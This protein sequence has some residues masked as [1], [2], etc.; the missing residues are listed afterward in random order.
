VTRFVAVWAGQ[1]V[2]LVGSGLS[3]FAIAVWVYGETGDVADLA[4]LACAGYLPLVVV[5]PYGG[6]LADRFDRRIV[7]LACD[8]ASAVAIALAL[9]CA[10]AG[11]LS[12]GVATLLVAVASSAGAIQWPAYEAALVAMVPADRLGRANGLVELSRGAA[13]LLAPVIGGVAYA[14]IGLGGILAIDVASF[15]I[16]ILPLVAIRFPAHPRP[17]REAADLRAAWQVVAKR[18]GL[19]AMLALFAVTNFTFAVTELAFRP[20]VLDAGDPW[21][22]G[23]VLSTVGCGM[24]AGAAAMAVWSARTASRVTAILAFQLVEGGALI[25]AGASTTLA[26]RCA[27][28]FAYGVVI[29]LTFGCARVIWQ[30]HIPHELQGRVAALRNAIVIA[31]IPIGYA[32]A[33]PIAYVLGPHLAIVAMGAVTWAAAVATFLFAPYRNVERSLAWSEA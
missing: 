33:A 6:V 15:A 16:G 31:A 29:P 10:G 17:P 9:G 8:L 1:L 2:S 24:V 13:Q 28:A 11:R 30:L 20:L 21:Q 4:R 18:R 14:A 23:V 32:A 5:A 27:A 3:A 12:P 25:A 7:M 26:G 19:V 22:L